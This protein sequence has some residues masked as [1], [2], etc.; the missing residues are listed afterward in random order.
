[1]WTTIGFIA[2]VL[3]MFGFVPQVLKMY[4]TRSV[5]DISF[6]ALVQ[7]SIGIFLWILYGIYLKN[8]IIIMANSVS[9]ST[10]IIALVLYFKYK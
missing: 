2:A 4:K 6:I 5:T 8:P 3:T 1:M 9:L 10:L 7:F